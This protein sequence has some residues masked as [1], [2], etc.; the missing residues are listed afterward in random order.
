MIKLNKL[1]FTLIELLAVIVIL[2]LIMAVVIP[3]VTWSLNNSKLSTLHS[4]AKSLANYFSEAVVT[5]EL[6]GG[7]TTED[8]TVSTVI[9]SNDYKYINK[10]TWVCLD[11]LSVPLKNTSELYAADFILKKPSGGKTPDANNPTEGINSKT[12]SAV[13]TKDGVVEV[14]LVAKSGGRFAVPGTNKV[15]YAYSQDTEAKVI[16][17]E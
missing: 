2:A 13:R 15:T 3:N 14:I 4:K 11:S 8:G 10:T 17:I 7:A 5:Y 12:C 9:N 16:E 6:S 1:G